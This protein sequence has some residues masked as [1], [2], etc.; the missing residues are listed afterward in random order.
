MTRQA[1]VLQVLQ[2]I[3]EGHTRVTARA[4]MARLG[5]SRATAYRCIAE[6]EQVGLLE[7]ASRSEYV[8]GPTVVE[9]D[10]LIRLNDP[11]LAAAAGIVEELSRRTGATILLT[12]LHGLKVVCVHDVVGPLGPQAV[13]YERGYA[14]GL[15]MSLFRG[16]TSKVILAHLPR[17][18]LAQVAEQ[19]AAE[20][21][22]G[23][24]PDALNALGAEMA[25]VRAAGV[26]VTSDEVVRDTRAWSVPLHQGRKLLGS[27]SLVFRRGALPSGPNL[28]V[29]QLRRA[30]RRIEG[31]LAP[32]P[33]QTQ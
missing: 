11:L 16:A 33:E 23:G 9:L 21:R 12:R 30:A 7:R 2:F 28:A 32:A 1:H 31:R 6:L 15:A 22:A 14:R 8:L 10:R 18:L 19:H 26:C 20:L 29:D 3:R 4:L 25:R 27:L 5:V 17:P 24:L 13:S